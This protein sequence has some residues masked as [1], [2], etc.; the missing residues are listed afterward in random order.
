MGGFNG[1]QFGPTL[2]PLFKNERAPKVGPPMINKRGGGIMANRVGG[3]GLYYIVLLGS[4]Q[5]PSGDPSTGVYTTVH[6]ELYYTILHQ[7]IL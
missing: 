7:T 2:G 6:Y 5:P 3:L 4:L 1:K